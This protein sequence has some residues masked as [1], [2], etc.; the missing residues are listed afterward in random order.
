[1]EGLRQKKGLL[2]MDNNVISARGKGGK[3]T[4]W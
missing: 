2:D 1:M 3:G 4:K